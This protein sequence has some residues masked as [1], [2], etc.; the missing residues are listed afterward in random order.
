[1]RMTKRESTAWAYA[2]EGRLYNVG[3]PMVPILLKNIVIL[4]TI[5]GKH[6]HTAIQKSLIDAIN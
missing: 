3:I 1:M 6:F 2:I 4:N 5:L